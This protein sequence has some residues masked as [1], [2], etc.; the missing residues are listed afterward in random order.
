MFVYRV[1][2]NK[3][4]LN[5]L[6]DQN[7]KLTG[8]IGNNTF[9]YDK[10]V[11]YKHF[12]KYLESAKMFYDGHSKEGY[13][14]FSVFDIPEELLKEHSGYGIYHGI[15]ERN[16]DVIPTAIPIPE[17]AIPTDVLKKE[18]LL[19]ISKRPF[20]KEWTGDRFHFKYFQYISYLKSLYSENN[21]DREKILDILLNNNLDAMIN[22]SK[23]KNKFMNK[24]K[25]HI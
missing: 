10:D 16:G 18:Y 22:K 3:E 5:L 7:I 4:V 25:K 6:D 20:Y 8:T 19:G 12:F 13:K 2:T 23:V 9:N 1:M 15:K 17:Y 24:I 11:T 21:A 14:W